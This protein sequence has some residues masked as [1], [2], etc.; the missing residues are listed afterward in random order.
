[1][2]GIYIHIPFCRQA[3]HYCNFHF[4][5]NLKL[6]S[7]MVDAL[8]K[9]WHLRKQKWENRKYETL[10]LGG[11]TPSILSIAELEKLLS[12][13][14]EISAFKEV[15]LEANPD[16]ITAEKL[17]A[18]WN[19]GIRR[20][21]VGI[22]SFQQKQLLW[23]NRAHNARES[24][25][26]LENIFASEFKNISIDLIY[27]LKNQTLK[28]WENE[29]KNAFQYPITHLSTYELTVEQGTAL[30][31]DISKGKYS[32][33]GDNTINAEY[34]LLMDWMDAYHWDHYEISSSARKGYRAIHNSRYWDGTP[35]IGLG[36]GAHSWD[37]KYR[38]WNVSH[39]LK[40]IKA[41]NSGTRP[42]ESELID[43]RTRYNE[44]L[45]TGLRRKEGLQYADLRQFPDYLQEYFHSA[46]KS[47]DNNKL[48]QMTEQSLSLTRAGKHYADRIAS[49]LMYV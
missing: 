42:A 8:V 27:G 38:S 11:G 3:C 45:M 28:D 43:D 14:G 35:Y 44:W 12:E 37:G 10:Y 29:L 49:D 17:S 6:R 26:C 46:I 22:Q 30:N 2:A 19:L 23:M 24:Q 48:T 5:T 39:N 9:E 13:F 40:Y 21:S 1:M 47:L 33:P 32:L 31:Y 20:L 16:D 25:L 36:P 7:A 41:I 15:T 4:S 34:D 18:W